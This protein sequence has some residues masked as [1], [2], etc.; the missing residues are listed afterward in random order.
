[1]KAMTICFR[2][3]HDD[4]DDDVTLPAVDRHNSLLADQVS[5][6]I[7]LSTHIRICSRR[8]HLKFANCSR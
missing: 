5:N 1:M 2:R 8:R 6:E 4:D 3:S 7:F